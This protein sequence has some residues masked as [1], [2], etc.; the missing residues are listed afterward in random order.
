MVLRV[1]PAQCKALCL[2]VMDEA[3]YDALRA[4]AEKMTDDHS[5]LKELLTRKLA[6]HQAPA[7][8]GL[9]RHPDVY[10]AFLILESL[11]LSSKDIAHVM[12]AKD[13]EPTTIR[14]Y[15]LNCRKLM[16]VEDFLAGR[17]PGGTAYTSTQTPRLSPEKCKALSVTLIGEQMYGDVLAAARAI[18]HDVKALQDLFIRRF[19]KHRTIKALKG[20]HPHHNVVFL[21]L[22]SL[23][24]TSSEIKAVMVCSSITEWREKLAAADRLA[25]EAEFAS[26]HAPSAF[27]AF[28]E[29]G[30][31]GQKKVTRPASPVDESLK[32]SD[33]EALKN[34]Q[35]KKSLSEVYTLLGRISPDWRQSDKARDRAVRAFHEAGYVTADIAYIMRDPADQLDARLEAMGRKANTGVARFASPTMDAA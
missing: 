22:E 28:K 17:K 9:G 26:R 27:N 8:K 6:C 23:Q 3:A 4:A 20:F 5:A 25:S 30:S 16:S 10:V 7:K 32:K 35:T 15:L 1:S 21:V 14:G 34:A 13:S 33:I 11:L 18:K 24:L 12:S 2:T 31:A 29:T 19:P